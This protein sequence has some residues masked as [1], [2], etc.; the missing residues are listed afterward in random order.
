MREFNGSSMELGLQDL[1][2]AKSRQAHLRTLRLDMILALVECPEQRQRRDLLALERYEKA[3]RS[4]QRR[5]LKR[6]NRDNR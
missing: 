6:L 1:A 2:Q 5:G 3:A 4:R